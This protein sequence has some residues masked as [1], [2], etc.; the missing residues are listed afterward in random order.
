MIRDAQDGLNGYPKPVFRLLLLGP[1]HPWQGNY[2][3]LLCPVLYLN[4]LSHEV[5]PQNLRIYPV[6]E[7]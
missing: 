4:P 7:W 5:R 2:I 3:R 6:R 1:T